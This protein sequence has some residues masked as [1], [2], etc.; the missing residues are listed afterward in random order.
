MSRKRIFKGK[1]SSQTTTSTVLALPAL[2]VL[3]AMV[4][5]RIFYVPVVATALEWF[6]ALPLWAIFIILIL[7]PLTAFFMAARLY[8]R[9]TVHRYRKF[10]KFTMA[11]SAFSLVLIGC[12]VI[13]H[14]LVG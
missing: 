1:H 13:A 8:S 2:L 14:Y 10:N 7:L 9:G 12:L 4:V 11:M 3:L 6:L 5:L